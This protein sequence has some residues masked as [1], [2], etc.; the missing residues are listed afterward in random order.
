MNPT[1]ILEDIYS[2]KI[3]S[4]TVDAD[5]ASAQEKLQAAW[6]QWNT[7]P[8]T[9]MFRNALTDEFQ[10]ILRGCC[11][12]VM[13]GEINDQQLRSSVAALAAISRAVNLVEKGPGPVEVVVNS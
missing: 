8:I 9:N 5:K 7:N 1:N 6:Q 13:T 4:D 2:N 11:N 10:Q 3:K 12:G